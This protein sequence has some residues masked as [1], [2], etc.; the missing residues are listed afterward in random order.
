MMSKLLKA[1]AYVKAPKQTF[2]VLHPWKAAKLGALFWIGKR[3]FGSHR[4]ARGTSR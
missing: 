2:A 3:L 4:R 1:G